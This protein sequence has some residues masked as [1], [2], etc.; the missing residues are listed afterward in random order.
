[1]FGL[2]KQAMR[3]KVRL[4]RSFELLFARQLLPG[5]DQKNQEMR[6]A[7]ALRRIEPIA[8]A[9]RRTNIPASPIDH[10]FKKS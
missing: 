6:P 7:H 4:T 10:L 3:Q 2:M 1:M 9:S 8:S 5:Q